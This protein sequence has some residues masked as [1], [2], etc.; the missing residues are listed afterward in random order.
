MSRRAANQAAARR[1]VLAN[2]AF[3]RDPVLSGSGARVGFVATEGPRI[4]VAPGLASVWLLVVLALASSRLVEPVREGRR[5][6]SSLGASR[7]LCQHD[8]DVPA[9]TW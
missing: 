9:A 4:V 8:G 1:Q 6:Y 2:R 5:S 3:R 7:G